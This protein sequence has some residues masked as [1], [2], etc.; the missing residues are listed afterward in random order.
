[1]PHQ[2]PHT[3]PT[4]CPVPF[5]PFRRSTPLHPPCYVIRCPRPYST[6]LQ[7]ACDHKSSGRE[8]W[9]GQ[10]LPNSVRACV[11]AAQCNA[12]RGCGL[13]HDALR[14]LRQGWLRFMPAAGGTTLLI[15]AAAVHPKRQQVHTSHGTLGLATADDTLSER[16]GACNEHART[17][18]RSQLIFLLTTMLL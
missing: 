11:C 14:S 18:V 10:L 1:L 2:L 8:L 3:P 7:H 13:R 15:S 16:C 5:L 4:S 12:S 6:F 17:M 9:C